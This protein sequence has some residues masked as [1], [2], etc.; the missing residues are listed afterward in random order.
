MRSLFGFAILAVVG[1][2]ALKLF[3]ALFGVAV[4]LF[5][6]LLVWAAMGFVLYM[7]IKIL[8]PGTAVKIREMVT[9][10]ASN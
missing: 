8:S 6:P 1:I 3:F 4:A 2:I 7:I 10:K 9:G 5:V